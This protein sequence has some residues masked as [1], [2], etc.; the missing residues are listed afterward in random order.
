MR[1]LLRGLARS[2][3]GVRSGV[4]LSAWAWKAL[5]AGRQSSA[6]AYEAIYA[7]TDPWSYESDEQRARMEL[8]VALVT[9]VAR[10]GPDGRAG[11]VLEVGCAEGAVSVHL[12]PLCVELVAADFSP[13]ST[14][15]PPPVAWCSISTCCRAMRRR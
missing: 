8:A 5:R 7:R 13:V 10:G 15:P 3:P 11:Q 14:L 1:R 6:E 2:V 9:E 4:Y 12:A